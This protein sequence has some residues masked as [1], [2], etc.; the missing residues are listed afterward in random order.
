MDKTLRI[1]HL[2]D[3]PDYSA[4]IQTMLEKEG[5]GAEVVLVDNHAAFS[6]ALER[7]AFD[8][9]LADYKLPT[10]DGIQALRTA[11]QKR[12][13][14]PFV[15][16]SGS[17]GEHAAIERL[18]NGATDDVLKQ[19]P[20]RLVPAVRRA[21]QE[22]QKRVQLKRAEVEL[23]RREKYFRAL[24]ENSLDVLTILRREAVL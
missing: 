14:T 24:T 7:E 20:E 5:L 13:K 3:D 10:C 16:V 12:P 2:E 18:K 19:W 4:L 15:L 8:V 6:A 11:R 9:I 22:A 21:V 17:I 1:L 23:V